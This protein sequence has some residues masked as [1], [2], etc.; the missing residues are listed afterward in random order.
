MTVFLDI[1]ILPILAFVYSTF[2]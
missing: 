2:L 1:D